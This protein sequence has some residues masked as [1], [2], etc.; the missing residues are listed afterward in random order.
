MGDEFRDFTLAAVQAAPV[1]MDR[2]ASI[3]K[4]CT[5]IDEAGAK[6]A[7]LAV[8]GETWVPGYVSFARFTGHPMA[9]TAL[10]RLVTNGVEVPGPATD[11]LCAAA[12]R[13]GID[14]AIGVA[15]RDSTTQGSIY[16]TLLFIGRDGTL[17]GKHRKLKPTYYERAVWGEGDGSSLVVYDR[18]YGKLGGLNCWEHQMVLPGYA[19]IAQGVQVHAAVWP[20]GTFSRQE[21]LCRAFAMQAGA[22]V[23]MSGG[24]LRPGDIPADLREIVL[25]SNG[26]SGIIGPDGSIL[27]GPLDD[28]EGILT[29]TGNLAVL[30]TQR[31]ISDHA[32]H[33]TRPDVFDF[34]VNRKPKRVARFDDSEAG[35]RA[36]I[37]RTIRD[38]AS[39][40]DIGDLHEL[41]GLLEDIEV[42]AE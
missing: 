17:L 15:E 4:A 28:E 42:Q 18:P 8:F 19:L 22:Y 35:R 26:H 32:G 31:M 37:V 10:Q 12:R 3:D 38:A 13:A 29:A 30:M 2:D 23:V 27:A 40:G 5:L 39:N 16:C 34:R 9:Y 24:L 25:P 21:I 33:Y 11:V 14:V 6:G 20:G 41:R 7:D 1:Y 36:T